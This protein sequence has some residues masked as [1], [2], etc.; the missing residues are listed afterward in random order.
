MSD[1]IS[2]YNRYSSTRFYGVPKTSPKTKPKM[3]RVRFLCQGCGELH[4]FFVEESP[5][6]CFGCLQQFQIFQRWEQRYGPFRGWGSV[7]DW[8]DRYNA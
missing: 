6:L 7:K 2:R 1:S 8:E 3:Y 5:K 4:L